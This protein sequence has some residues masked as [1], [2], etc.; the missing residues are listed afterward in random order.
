MEW[1]NL[2][3][4]PNQLI[5]EMWVDILQK[6]GVPAFAKLPGAGGYMGVVLGSAAPT[7][8]WVMVPETHLKIAA[9]IIEPMLHDKP[10]KRPT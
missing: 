4:A 9:A 2:V 6:E 7:G 3:T 5:A 10:P 8:C 1:V